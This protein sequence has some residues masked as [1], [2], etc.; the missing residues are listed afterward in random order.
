MRSPVLALIVLLS[1][2]FL[3]VTALRSR[4]RCEKPDEIPN[5]TIRLRRFNVL[6]IN[7][8]RGFSLEGSSYV[9]C[10]HGKWKSEKAVCYSRCQVPEG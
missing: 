8:K 1:I 10:E 5:A 4:I 9:A 6:R 3:I 7:C 2:N